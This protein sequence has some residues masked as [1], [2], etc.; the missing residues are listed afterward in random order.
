MFSLCYGK[1]YEIT[2]CYYKNLFFMLFK[3]L[4]LHFKHQNGSVTP[5]EYVF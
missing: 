1:L 2:S 4:L 3:E 5:A